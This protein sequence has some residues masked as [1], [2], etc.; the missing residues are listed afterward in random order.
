MRM[1]GCDRRASKGKGVSHKVIS[2]FYF[3]YY[4]FFRVRARPIQ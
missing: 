4:Y 1:K 2:F 3:Y